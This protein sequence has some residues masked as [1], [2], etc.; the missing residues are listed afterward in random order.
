[1]RLDDTMLQT[2]SR[3]EIL[4]NQTVNLEDHIGDLQMEIQEAKDK[5]RVKKKKIEALERLIDK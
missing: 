3:V 1:M 4:R 5:N 2:D